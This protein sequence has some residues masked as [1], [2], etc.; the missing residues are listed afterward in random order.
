MGCDGCIHEKEDRTKEPCEPCMASVLNGGER[1]N[2]KEVPKKTCTVEVYYEH[3]YEAYNGIYDYR[4]N[5]DW[6]YIEGE[7]RTYIKLDDVKR[8]SVTKDV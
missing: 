8:I 5:G 2:Y 4:F 1:I 3:N 7:E 6:L